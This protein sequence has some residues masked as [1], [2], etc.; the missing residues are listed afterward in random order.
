MTA[1]N[2]RLDNNINLDIFKLFRVFCD[3]YGEKILWSKHNIFYN[4]LVD[5]RE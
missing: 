5:L 1:N 4:I 3:V 2:I